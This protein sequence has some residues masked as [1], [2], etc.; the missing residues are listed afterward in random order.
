[1]SRI[2]LSPPDVRPLE[3][4]LITAAIE[5]GWIAPVGPDLDRFE[6]DVAA[7]AGVS[8]AV[9]LASGTAALHLAL[10]EA[11]VTRGDV[12]LMS[13]F[14]F[15]ATANAVSYVGAEPVFVDS[16]Q[17]T[18]NLSPELLAEELSARAR[19]G[20]L[21]KA[22][23]VVDLYGQCADYDRI[24]GTLDEFGVILIED[25]AEALGATYRNQPAGAFGHSAVVSF[26]GNKII[27]TSGGGMFLCNDRGRA[28]RVR[29]LA[30]QARKPVSHYEH[31]ELGFNY[32][33]SNLLAAFGRGQLATLPERIS[34][35]KEI[36]DRYE[37]AL[38]GVPGVQFQ[39]VADYG[40]P[41]WWLTCITVDPV[42]ADCSADEMRRH[43]EDADIESR[44]LWKP[45]HLQPLFAHSSRRVDGTAERLFST[46]LCLPSGSSMTDEELERVLSQILD[47]APTV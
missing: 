23:I 46:G 27:T 45:M 19:V 41:N 42:V 34:R 3:K 1:M 11:G 29:H 8:H 14:T 12:V 4:E 15:V 20:R 10:I 18:W 32:R 35:R 7:A 28:D 24:I 44:P 31:V 25:A 17:S 21:P 43:L 38:R 39:P 26:N 5:S 47:Y 6:R 33:L 13:T 2:Y 30:T 22:C 16:D 40:D 36:R 37:A 9:G